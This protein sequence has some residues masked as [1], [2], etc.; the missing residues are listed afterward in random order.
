MAACSFA[1][2]P[3]QTVLRIEGPEWQ[4]V[5]PSVH[6]RRVCSP[7]SP[8]DVSPDAALPCPAPVPASGLAKGSAVRVGPRA[9]NPQ[10]LTDPEKAVQIQ[11]CHHVAVREVGEQFTDPYYSRMEQMLGLASASNGNGAQQL[12]RVRINAQIATPFGCPKFNSVVQNSLYLIQKMRI[13][14]IARLRLGDFRW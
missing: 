7:A 9:S 4:D 6:Q 12:V 5:R 14:Q 2:V 10:F 11:Y 3:H 13:D 8:T 1:M